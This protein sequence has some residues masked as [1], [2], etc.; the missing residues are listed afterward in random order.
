MNA[1]ILPPDSDDLDLE[2]SEADE[3]EDE[4]EEGPG[5]RDE[6]G[7]G[8]YGIDLNEQHQRAWEMDRWSGDPR[9]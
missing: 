2:V 1:P 5:V 8:S 4:D 9:W 6:E 7:D 3:D